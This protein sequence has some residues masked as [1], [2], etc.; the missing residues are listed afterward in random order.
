MKKVV[1]SVSL[2]FFMLGSFVFG[3]VQQGQGGVLAGP[4]CAQ[5]V[6][7]GTPICDVG[8]STMPP[9]EN[10]TTGELFC[11]RPISCR[12]QFSTGADP[13]CYDCRCNMRMVYI[14]DD[15]EGQYTFTECSCCPDNPDTNNY[16]EPRYAV[17]Y[18]DEE[19]NVIIPPA[20]M[21]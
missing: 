18:I 12:Q 6:F 21:P 10:P 15:F 7:M 5:S 19:G 2:A 13:A 20:P 1:M 4:K 11:L 9:L 17:E 16:C 14:V 8:C 3:Q